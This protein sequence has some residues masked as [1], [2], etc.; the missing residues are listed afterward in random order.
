MSANSFDPTSRPR[1]P[2]A[3]RNADPNEVLSAPC[4]RRRI[5][6]TAYAYY[7]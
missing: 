7:L 3:P 2:D 5:A 1:T 6:R 4:S